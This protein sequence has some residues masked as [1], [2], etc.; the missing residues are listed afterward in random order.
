MSGI[1]LEHDDD[2]LPSSSVSLDASD[3]LSSP[4]TMVGAVVGT[5]RFMA[6]EQHAGVSADAR[7]DQ[8]SFCVALYQALYRQDPYSASNLERLALAKQLGQIRR[9][10]PDIKLPVHIADAL[11][12]GLATDPGDRWPDM[13]TL[14]DALERD[15]AA[16]RR[17]VLFVLGVATVAAASPRA[18]WRYMPITSPTSRRSACHC[19][20]VG[21]STC[22][23]ATKTESPTV[24]TSNTEITLGCVTRAIA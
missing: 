22:S 6:P 10:P 2:D 5:P 3:V 15:P 9:P 13:A 4:L 19:V 11:T 16:A 17:R 18:A 7:S 14:I 20:S 12:R 1:D 8:F 24:P 21:P 23:I